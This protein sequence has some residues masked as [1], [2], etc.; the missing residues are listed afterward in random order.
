MENVFIDAYYTGFPAA[1]KLPNPDG[2]ERYN[3]MNVVRPY[4][5]AGTT[6]MLWRY[7]SDA[8]DV[9]FSYLPVIRRVRRMSPASRS[10]ALLGSDFAQ[11]DI[12]GYE[13]KVADFEWKLIEKKEALVPFF[14]QDPVLIERNEKGEYPASKKFQPIIY[15][16]QKKGWNAAPW[17]PINSVYTKRSVYVIELKPKDPYYNYGTQYLWMDAE[18]SMPAYKLIFDRGGKFWK[19]VLVHLLPH[20]SSDGKLDC[21][22]AGDHVVVDVLR[23]HATRL[24]NLNLGKEYTLNAVVDYNDFSLAGV[25]KYCK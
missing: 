13:G 11:D 15:G 23:D 24:S 4:D 9:N 10:D 3:I 8:R 17:C 12:L 6:V 1:E 19:F 25:Q 7:L 2:I 14:S 22:G 20:K 5:L 18:A 16:Y 21:V